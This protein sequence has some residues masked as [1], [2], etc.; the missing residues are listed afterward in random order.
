MDKKYVTLF[1][2]LAQAMAVSAEMVMEY[3][4]EKGDDKGLET[5]TIM[6][7]D[8][9][10]L[11]DTIDNLGKDYQMNK[12]DAAKFLVG[13]MVQV[14]HLQDKINS[15]KMAIKGY[16]ED[17]IPKLK[18]IVDNAKDDD[19]ASKMMEEKFTLESNE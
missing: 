6:R 3:D 12:N 5:A 13:A 15:I 4:R 10:A 19:D 16:Q 17:L 11:S 14:N 9:Q 7:D 8:Y 2:E 1:K 18:E